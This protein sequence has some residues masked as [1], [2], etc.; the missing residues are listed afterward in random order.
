MTPAP[1]R[2]PLFPGSQHHWHVRAP[3]TEVAPNECFVFGSNA[4]GF[5]GAGAAGQACRGDGRNTWRDDAWFLAAQ[6]APVGSHARVG[7]WAV[8]GQARGFQQGREGCSYAIETIRRPGARRSTPL[9]EIYHQVVDLVG[10]ARTR[11]DLIFVVTN[12]GERLAG[13][14]TEELSVVWREVATRAGIPETFRFVRV[15]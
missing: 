11:A 6:R 13:Y 8:Y 10:F 14:T 7:L 1:D 9:R 3:I 15:G 12:I 5:H 2:L 4:D